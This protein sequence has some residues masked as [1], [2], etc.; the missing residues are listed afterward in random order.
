MAVGIQA[1][2]MV[3]M[4]EEKRIRGDSAL[5]LIHAADHLES[6]KDGL[7]ESAMDEIYAEVKSFRCNVVPI[8]E[9]KHILRTGLSAVIAQ[10][11]QIQYEPPAQETMLNRLYQTEESFVRIQSYWY[12]LDIL[13]FLKGLKIFKD[14]IWK[15]LKERFSQE[16]LSGACFF[17]MEKRVSGMIHLYSL[18][19][20]ATSIRSKEEIIRS[21]KREIQNW[22]EV[23][24]SASNIELKIPCR[25]E[26]AVIGRM[27][28]EAIAR[29]L[30]Y[31][32]EEVQDIKS[33][34]GEAVDNAIEHGVSEKGIDLHY[35]LSPTDLVIEII[36][37]GCGFSPE[38]MGAVPPEPM[39]ERGRGIFM[40]RHLL[41][42]ISINS[43]PGEGTQA[44]MRKKRIYR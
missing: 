25:E 31:D 36:D 12:Q 24:K 15:A 9:T 41:D 38:G 30:K 1:G 19:G 32:E 23:I 18:L 26:F 43:S 40:M 44:V 11:R 34:V 10:L 35:H 39:A 20:T 42:N 8:E 37:Y 28:A 3:I 17:E 29:R 27:Q 16:Q 6:R 22:E 2:C 33:A 21:H 4:E 13:D 14:V 5:F 7:I